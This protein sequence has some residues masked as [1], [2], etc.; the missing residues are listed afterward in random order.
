VLDCLLVD[1]MEDMMVMM[2]V[3]MKAYLLVSKK[4][5]LMVSM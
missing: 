2:W 5:E 3:G 4:V 1:L